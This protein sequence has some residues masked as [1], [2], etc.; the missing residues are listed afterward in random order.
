MSALGSLTETL[1]VGVTHGGPDMM[2]VPPHDLSSNSNACGPYPP[3]AQSLREADARHY[4]DPSYTE[5]IVQLATW[6]GVAPSRIVLGGS[7]SELIQRLSVAVAIHASASGQ[8]ASVWVPVHA[9]GDYA[10]AANA[11][12]L[13]RVP[14]S[15]QATLIW[16]CDPSSPLGL[17]HENLAQQVA[18]LQ[19]TQTMVLDQAYAPLRLSGA[20]ALD[21][22]GLDRVWRLITPNKALGLTG[23]R[24]A[25][26]IAPRHESALLARVRAL[27]PSWPI[28]AH[29]V[30]LLQCWATVDADQWLAECRKTLQIWK[31][32]Q[33]RLL[34][35]SGWSVAPSDANFFVI[36]RGHEARAEG[37][38]DMKTSLEALR[39]RGIKLRDCASFG[40]PGRARMAVTSPAVQD[41]LMRALSEEGRA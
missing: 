31:A 24:A 21:E 40:L 9:Y 6:H 36:A 30:A 16:A 39:L 41:E 35:A 18:T 33:I 29:G 14:G 26:A 28:G 4:P 11:A 27:A 19:A 15:E 34:S 2:G 38:F 12:G 8:V 13:R 5:L 3:A 20:L 25:Y 10:H 32:R 7:G 37:E 1:D 17:A 22:S 23:V